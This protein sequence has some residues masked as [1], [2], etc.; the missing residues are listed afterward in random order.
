M[1][2]AR[3]AV[4]VY[5]DGTTRTQEEHFGLGG[6]TFT[7]EGG[8]KL[9]FLEPHVYKQVQSIVVTTVYH[10]RVEV[11]QSGEETKKG[12]LKGLDLRVRFLPNEPKLFNTHEIPTRAQGEI[13]C[14]DL[15]CNSRDSQTKDT[16]ALFDEFVR[17]LITEEPKPVKSMPMNF[18]R[19]AFHVNTEGKEYAHLPCIHEDGWL[20]HPGCYAEHNLENM[21]F[22]G[23]DF[24]LVTC[25]PGVGEHVKEIARLRRSFED[26]EKSKDKQFA[27]GKKS[28]KKSKSKKHAL[29]RI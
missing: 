5:T 14:M 6:K 4:T 21:L 11:E 25:H 15:G 2:L 20:T 29:K 1:V 17:N 28:K 8:R 12:R 27:K 26:A 24:H 22:L 3:I 10:D 7:L 23:G 16:M 13:L 18:G 9:G 19:D